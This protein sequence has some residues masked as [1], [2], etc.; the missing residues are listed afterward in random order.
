MPR[1]AAN[2]SLLWTELPY[3][4]R[5]AAAADAGFEGA[6]VLFPY[7]IA[8]Q[9]TRRALIAAG[10]DFV[11]MNAPPPNYTGGTPGYAALPGPRF[12]RD[13]RRVLRYTEVLRPRF[14]HIM[15]GEAEGAD[16]HATFIANLR[17]AADQA[18]EQRFTIEPL[19]SGTFP[20]YFLNDYAQAIDILDEVDRPNVGL[21]YDTFHAQE[22]TGDA[23]ACWERVADRAVHIQIGDA[24]GRGAP[25]SGALD[26]AALFEAFRTSGYDGWI[27]AEYKPEGRTEAS[28]DWMTAQ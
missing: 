7:D 10:L 28:L 2:L 12:E 26:F 4:D 16:A 5:F 25:G 27:S 1:F 19:N 22:I 6:E 18:P 21:Q 20:G 13:I 24:P 8:A 15:S 9:D 3:L 17:H 11:L 14:V 23:L